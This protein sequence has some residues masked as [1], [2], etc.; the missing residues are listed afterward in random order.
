M[1]GPRVPL[2]RAVRTFLTVWK[3]GHAD[4][5]S[6]AIDALYDAYEQNRKSQNERQRRRYNR[7][8]E[9]EVRHG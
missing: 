9:E 7:R 1:T 5:L 4:E 6:P 2:I 8:R 3:E